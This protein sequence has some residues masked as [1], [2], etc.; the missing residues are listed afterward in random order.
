M[1]TLEEIRQD[2]K[3]DAYHDWKESVTPVKCSQCGVGDSDAWTCIGT[4]PAYGA[5]ADGRRGM[6]AREWECRCGNVVLVVG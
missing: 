4:D 1:S 6:M 2:A 3:R 5:D